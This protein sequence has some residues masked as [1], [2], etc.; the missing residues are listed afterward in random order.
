MRDTLDES[1]RDNS[2]IDPYEI[3]ILYNTIYSII[4]K[5][6][7]LVYRIEFTGTDTRYK[8]DRSRIIIPELLE[9]TITLIEYNTILY[10]NKIVNFI[11][12]EFGI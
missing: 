2:Q 3:T 4:I 1:L 5:Y 9:Y 11:Y 8:I 7:A 12:I 6:R 10:Q